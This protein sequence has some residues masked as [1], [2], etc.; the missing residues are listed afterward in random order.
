[1]AE[2]L[3]R[4]EQS[5]IL[6]NRRGFATSVICRQCSAVLDCPN[7][8]ISLTVHRQGDRIPGTLSLLQLHQAGAERV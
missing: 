7:C 4:Q 8:S 6:L 2:R 5:L 1:M 3:E